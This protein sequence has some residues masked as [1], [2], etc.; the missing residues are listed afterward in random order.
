MLPGFFMPLRRAP[1][2]RSFHESLDLPTQVVRRLEADI[3]NYPLT[4][5]HYPLTSPRVPQPFPQLGQGGALAVHQD[6][7]AVDARGE[8][9]QPPRR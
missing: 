2:K 3:R 1:S 7:D 6:A 5:N 4:T 8:S 9:Q